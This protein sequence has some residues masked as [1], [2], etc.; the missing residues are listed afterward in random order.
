M[1]NEPR[2]KVLRCYFEQTFLLIKYPKCNA[3]CAVYMEWEYPHTLFFLS[4]HYLD[5]LY[6]YRRVLGLC[7][8]FML[9]Y[10]MRIP[11]FC[12]RVPLLNELLQE[13]RERKTILIT[14][15]FCFSVKKKTIL[16][17]SSRHQWLNRQKRKC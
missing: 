14:W 2:H 7:H 10:P 12:R 15:Y 5:S 4:H 13:A 11:A 16:D 17:F 8:A 3:L 9:S 6:K 1:R